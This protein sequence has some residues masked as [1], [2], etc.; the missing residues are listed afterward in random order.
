LLY[1]V[2]REP[3]VC[4]DACFTPYSAGRLSVVNNLY[5]NHS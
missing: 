4:R 3:P 5:G 1:Y 2:P